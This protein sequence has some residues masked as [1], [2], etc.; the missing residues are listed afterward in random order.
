[1]VSATSENPQQAITT[2]MAS[3]LG[4]L[5]SVEAAHAA[6]LGVP[7]E[8]AP[9]KAASAVDGARAIREASLSILQGYTASPSRTVRD[10]ESGQTSQLKCPLCC[11]DLGDLVVDDARENSL[12]IDATSAAKQITAA[13]AV[14]VFIGGQRAVFC[15]LLDSIVSRDNAALLLI[16]HDLALP[17]H[18]KGLPIASLGANGLQGRAH[19]QRVTESGTV[20]S[21]DQLHDEGVDGAVAAIAAF[22]AGYQS[23]YCLVDMAVLDTGHAAGTPD[24]NIGGLSPQQ[25]VDVVAKLNLSARLAGVAV[26]N[27]APGLDLRAQT[28]FVAAQVL[29]TLLSHYLFAEPA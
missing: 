3:A 17:S 28:E 6:V 24:A 14:P 9:G 7:V 15:T 27:V 23:I 20:I 16:S 26:T 11:V 29:T 10:P 1:M 25:L 8:Q 18:A 2:F 12:L 13:G 19:W 21:A 5:S 22:V 4:E